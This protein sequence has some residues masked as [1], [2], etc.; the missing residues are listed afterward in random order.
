MEKISNQDIIKALK[1]KAEEH[2][3]LAT[4]F[5]GVIQK[6]EEIDNPDSILQNKA[7]KLTRTKPPAGTGYE[8]AIINIFYDGIPRTAREIQEELQ[9][10]LK[11]KIMYNTFSGRLSEIKKNGN[12][13]I[14]TIPQNPL[15]T[16]YYYG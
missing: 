2:E 11:R 15:T 7:P 4:E 14:H 12:I 3:R 16:R 9:K 13:R 5:R 10:V 6:L 8:R 1:L